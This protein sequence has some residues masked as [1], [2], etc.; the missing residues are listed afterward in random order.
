MEEILDI[1]GKIGFDLFYILEG[2]I[3]EKILRELK[4]QKGQNGINFYILGS[5]LENIEPLESG[6]IFF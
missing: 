5:L 4:F 2:N 1:T 3:S 6:L